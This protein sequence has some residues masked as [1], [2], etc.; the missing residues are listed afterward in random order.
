MRLGRHV[1]WRFISKDIWGQGLLIFTAGYQQL[2]ANIIF[3]FF[4]KKE[5]SLYV[6]YFSTETSVEHQKF[7][8]DTF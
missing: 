1:G 4:K 6:I 3:F 7:Q 5:K 2:L 8:E